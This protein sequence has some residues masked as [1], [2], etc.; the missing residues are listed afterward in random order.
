MNMDPC[1][2]AEVGRKERQAGE[3]D[4]TSRLP[5]FL[6]FIAASLLTAQS[7]D[8]RQSA[9]ALEQQGKLAE[10]EQAWRAFLKTHPSDAEPYAHLGLLEARQDHYKEAVP[11]YRKA[12]ALKPGMPGLRLNLGLALFKAGDLKAAIPEFTILLKNAPPHSPEALRYTIL[13]GMSHYGLGQFAE[14]APYLKTAAAADPQ[15]LPIRLTLAH[16]YLW[17]KQYNRVLDVYNEILTLDPDSAEA[18]ML[19]GEAL[20]EMKDTSGAIEMFRKA[21]NAKPDEPNVHFGLGYLLWSQ[22]QYPEAIKEFQAELANDPNHAQSMLYIADAY[23]QMNQYADAAPLLEKAVKLDPSARSRPSRPRHPRRQRRPQR[24]RAS[25]ISRRRK[26]HSQRR[27][28]ALAPRPS[29]PRHGQKRRSQSRTRQGQ[30]HHP[31][32]R[33]GTLQEDFRRANQA[34]RRIR[35]ASSSNRQIDVAL[36]RGLCMRRD[37]RL[38]GKQA[39]PA[40]SPDT[41]VAIRAAPDP[42]PSRPTMRPSSCNRG[43]AYCRS[44][45]RSVFDCTYFSSTCPSGARFLDSTHSIRIRKRDS[46]HESV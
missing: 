43:T 6:F 11:L 31:F 10:T 5:L 3:T 30:H 9:I 27:Q 12:L 14:A 41:C 4:R 22:K 15:N 29:L 42:L 16:S 35:T 21:V 2:S 13:L 34:S 8:L 37:R 39:A 38:F 44:R 23:I 7:A 1:S 46:H 32:G 36:V 19:A 40:P 18:D 24:R 17:S 26:A 25:R 33:P 45:F 28:R 20:D